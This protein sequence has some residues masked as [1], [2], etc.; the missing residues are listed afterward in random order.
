MR[1]GLPREFAAPHSLRSEIFQT[2]ISTPV[3]SIGYKYRELRKRKNF[4]TFGR[5]DDGQ[6]YPTSMPKAKRPAGDDMVV[7]RCEELTHVSR[8]RE[9]VSGDMRKIRN[10]KR[11]ERNCERSRHALVARRRCA[12]SY[13]PPWALPA[14]A[15]AKGA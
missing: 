8:K 10:L 2:V 6:D 14:E 4:M 11:T 9:P 12:L 1:R 7:I 5:Q 3:F 13:D 15:E